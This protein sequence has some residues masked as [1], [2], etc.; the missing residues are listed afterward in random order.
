MTILKRTKAFV[1]VAKADLA[2]RKQARE[3][4][5]KAK[6]DQARAD[7]EA[8]MAHIERVKAEAEADRLER[9]VQADIRNKRLHAYRQ[10]LSWCSGGKGDC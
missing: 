8:V 9:I 2:S 1:D 4:A 7:A 5:R 10:R 6:A 3:S